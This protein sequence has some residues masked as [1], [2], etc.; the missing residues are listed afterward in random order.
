MFDFDCQTQIHTKKPTSHSSEY[1]RELQQL[2]VGVE[3]DLVRERGQIV[4]LWHMGYEEPS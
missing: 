4:A 2:C 1:D 3:C